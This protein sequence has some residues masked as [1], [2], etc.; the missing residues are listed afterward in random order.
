MKSPHQ[1]PIIDVILAVCRMF[2]VK[3]F[4]YFWN[5]KPVIYQDKSGKR[6]DPV[7]HLQCLGGVHFNPLIKDNDYALIV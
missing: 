5:D 2:K 3:V 6:D 7:V 4:V 1:L